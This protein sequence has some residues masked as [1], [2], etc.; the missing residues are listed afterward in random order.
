MIETGNKDA[1]LPF[2]LYIDPEIEPGTSHKATAFNQ[3]CKPFHRGGGRLVKWHFTCVTPIPI[4]NNFDDW[5]IWL[6]DSLVVTYL[7]AKLEDAGWNPAKVKYLYDQCYVNIYRF[8]YL[9][10]S[11][12]C[13]VITHAYGCLIWDWINWRELFQDI[14]LKWKHLFS[15]V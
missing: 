1:T 12:L 7:T 6:S 9:Y 13:L 15:L 5:S 10:M 4:C 2:T 8:M 14:N 3:V 11:I